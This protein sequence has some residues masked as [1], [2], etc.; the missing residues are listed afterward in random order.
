MMASSGGKILR[1]EL[2]VSIVLAG[3]GLSPTF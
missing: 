1:G 3:V 2:D